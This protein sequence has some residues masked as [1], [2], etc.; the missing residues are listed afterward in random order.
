LLGFC[1]RLTHSRE[2]AGAGGIALPAGRCSPVQLQRTVLAYHV[3]L[4]KRHE[5]AFSSLGPGRA[6]TGRRSGVRI[7]GRA[8]GF[9]PIIQV[10]RRQVIQR[11]RAAETFAHPP[12]WRCC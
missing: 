12:A 5:F 1:S 11:P 7:Q 8:P 6:P 4:A 9:I 10:I 3:A 2:Q